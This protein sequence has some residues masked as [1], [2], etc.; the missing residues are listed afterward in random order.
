MLAHL[1]LFAKVFGVV[2]SQ[3]S[4][5]L[6]S[7][8]SSSIHRRTY[9]PGSNPKNIVVVGASF[10]GY[11]AARCLVNS[12][13]SGYRVIII[14]K[15]SHF[16]FTWV[17]PRFSVVEG[18]DKKA[19][20]PY[21]PFLRA[22]PGSHLWIKDTVEEI[23]PSEDGSSGGN[24][25]VSSGETFDFEYLVLATGSSA[26]L[27][28][29]VG[30]EDKPA[31]IQALHDQR[32]K[33]AGSHDIVV[34]GGGP[35]GVELVA[36]A[37]GQF[38]DKNVTLIHS[39][40]TLLHEGFGIKIHDTLSKALLE[41]G[42]NLVLGEKPAV[43]TGETVGD[44]ELSDDLVHFDCLIKCVGQKP[45]TALVKFAA[46]SA[47][48][49]SGHIRI[50]PSLQI[51]D[52]KYP[53]I[54]AAGDV[55]DAG[56]IKN[57]RSAMQQGQVVAQNIVRAIR[58]KSQIEYQQKWWEGLTKLTMGLTKSVAYASDGRAEWVIPTKSK[59]DLDCPGVWKFLGATPFVDPDE[60]KEDN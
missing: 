21:G 10:A 32:E 23:I 16:Q 43:P 24:I 51:A 34:I 15:N 59:I 25:R 35:A 8:I 47:F 56:N 1:L 60:E 39:R 42:V 52:D 17:L 38:P 12:I 55:I 3:A 31:G 45:N 30:Q 13:P 50:K 11:N 48:S 9:S 6:R 44:I 54:Y 28:S 36:D 33:I 26:A 49:E 18:H 22:P 58:G 4:T 37:K 20:I 41:L 5:Y 57:G 2:F 14:E 27:P 46:S 53:R 19:F 7:F 29:R 40:K